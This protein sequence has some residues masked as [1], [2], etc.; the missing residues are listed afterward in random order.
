MK[1]GK[2]QSQLIKELRSNKYNQTYINLCEGEDCF[3]FVGLTMFLHGW[4]PVSNQP[5]NSKC[6]D[7]RMEHPTI[8][9]HPTYEA[10]VPDFKFKPNSLLN[11]AI[12]NDEK[13][14][15]FK[16]FADMLEQNPEKYF[17]ESA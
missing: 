5:E 16:D 14:T 3:C 15:S 11:L 17:R 10:Q 1:L 7:W 4:K 9:L 13:Q 2:K 8:S 12:L 6:K